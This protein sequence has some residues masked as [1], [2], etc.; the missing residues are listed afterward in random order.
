MIWTASAGAGGDGSTA[1]IDFVYGTSFHTP[2]SRDYDDW[3]R[4]LE[5]RGAKVQYSDECEN[6]GATPRC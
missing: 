2:S 4:E 5:A 6:C 1:A 3:F